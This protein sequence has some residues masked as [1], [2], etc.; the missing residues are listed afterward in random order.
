MQQCI[1]G[2][3]SFD[4][5]DHDHLCTIWD[6]GA[7]LHTTVSSFISLELSLQPIAQTFYPEKH[8]ISVEYKENDVQS[9][10]FWSCSLWDWVL[11]YIKDPHFLLHTQWNLQH[12]YK[13]DGARYVRFIHEPYTADRFWT[14]QV[15]KP[16]LLIFHNACLQL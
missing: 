7:I 12:L 9:F 13:F 3:D 8:T 11:E 6:A 15:C 16:F 2:E 1:H 10:D 5:C 14:I 4:I